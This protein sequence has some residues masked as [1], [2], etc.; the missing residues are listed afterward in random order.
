MRKIGHSL[1]VN[2]LRQCIVSK[3]GKPFD[4]NIALDESDYN[5]IYLVIDKAILPLGKHKGVP[6]TFDN[7]C[8]ALGVGLYA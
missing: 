5:C 8:K 1:F 2:E 7:A 6:Q 3:A 4:L